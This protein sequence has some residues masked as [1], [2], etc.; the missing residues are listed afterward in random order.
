MSSWLLCGLL[1]ASLVVPASLA[2]QSDRASGRLTID[3]DTIVLR[4]VLA[5]R[6]APLFDKD[7]VVTQ[8]LITAQPVPADALEDAWAL[9]GAVREDKVT[10]LQ[11]EYEQDGRSVTAQF[12]SSRL[13]GTVSVSRS[14]S[15]AVPTELTAT[16]TAGTFEAK[17]TSLEDYTVAV[18]ATW[19]AR[20]M[21]PPVVAEPTAADAAAALEHPAV[22][23]WQAI[24]RAIHAGDKAALLAV[25]PA[26]I[27]SMASQPD[28]DA[29]FAGM[30]DMTPLVSRYLRV[31][32]RNGKAIIEAEAPGL[33]DKKTKRGTITMVRDGAVWWVE[34]M[35]F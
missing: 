25:A 19:S 32:E 5:R 10:G 21:A 3:G 35:T 29:G 34:T 23:A 20:V 24:A 11:L 7:K 22:K 30:K 15:S 33:M 31:T 26:S 12:L 8:V 16:R 17:T 1:T 2:A 28:F 9:I 6:V 18:S 14:G 4:H 13:A 27:K